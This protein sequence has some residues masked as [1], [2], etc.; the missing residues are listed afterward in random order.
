MTEWKKHFNNQR[1]FIP[2]AR[3][4]AYEGIIMTSWSTSGLYG[5][6]W[7]V[8]YNVVEMKQ[9]RNTYPLSGF[10]ILIVAYAQA[11]KQK[12]PINPKEFVTEYAMERFQLSAKSGK[13]LWEALTVAPELIVN[14]KPTESKSIAEMRLNSEVAQNILYM[15]KPSN[16]KNEFGHFRLM[17]D[18]RQNYLKFKEIELKYN[19]DQ[20]TDEGI[21]GLL[22]TLK[23]V[24]DQARELDLRF[25]DLNKDFLY[26]F[27]IHEQNNIRVKS[28]KILYNRLAKK[29]N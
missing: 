1:D 3:K 7:D 6:N 25:M 27:E 14:G 26:D 2:Y 16:H 9:I 15:L 20:F 13:K 4:A 10:R 5:F 19:S 18:L 17:A 11:L 29:K 28:M 21:N 22:L 12:E 23:K 24:L 8:G